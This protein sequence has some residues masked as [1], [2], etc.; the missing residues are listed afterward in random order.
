MPVF[1]RAITVGESNCSL[2]PGH[3]TVFRIGLL[4]GASFTF[5]WPLALSVVAPHWTQPLL[6]P[7]GKLLDLFIHVLCYIRLLRALHAPPVFTC[8]SSITPAS[9]ALF[10]P[11]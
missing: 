2:I 5:L 1:H 6:Q 3:V 4:N 7:A 8:H 11:P 9:L 10:R